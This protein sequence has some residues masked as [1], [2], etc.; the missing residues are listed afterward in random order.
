MVDGV[1]LDAM[2]EE[3]ARE[4]VREGLM[5]EREGRWGL[6]LRG[7]LISNE[8]FGRLLEAVAV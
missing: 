7:R 8:V 2:L 1:A 3:G 5:W 6:T 4:L